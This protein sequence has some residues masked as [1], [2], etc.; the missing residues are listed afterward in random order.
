MCRQGRE[1]KKLTLHGLMPKTFVS[2]QYLTKLVV[3]GK[4]NLDLSQSR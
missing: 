3:T 1:T 2:P 4:T